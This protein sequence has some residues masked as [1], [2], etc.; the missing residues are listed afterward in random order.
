MRLQEQLSERRE[1]AE[2]TLMFLDVVY[3]Y[4]AAT[5]KR[6][7]RTLFDPTTCTCWDV[8]GEQE[9]VQHLATTSSL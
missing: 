7:L 4:Q 8:N 2:S 3:H 1:S 6:N 9:R 5:F